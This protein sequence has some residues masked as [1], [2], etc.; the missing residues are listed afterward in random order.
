MKK[1]LSLMLVLALT[2]GCV[3]AL[4]AGVTV[5]SSDF[6]QGPDGWV[7]RSMGSAWI[8]AE[9]GA[10]RIEGR[11]SDWHSPGRDFDLKE[12]VRYTLRVLVMQSETEHA[13]FMIS[14]AHKL[15]GQET[16]ENLAFAT[17][18]RGAWTTLQCEYTP[19][20]FDSYVLYVETKGAPTLSYSIKN[21]VVA[22]PDGIPRDG[23]E[24]VQLPILKD[25]YAGQFDIGIAVPQ[26]VIRNGGPALALVQE[27]FNI[28]TP[29]NE[30]KPD[31]VLDVAAS[32]R[33][34]QEDETAAAVHFDAAKPLLDFAK[35][36]GI[37][38]HG[39]VLVW[40][41]QTPEAFFHEGYDPA[42]PYVSREVM[43][44]RLE[45]YI[46]GVMEYMDENYPGVVVS[47]DVVN[48]AIDDGGNYLRPSNWTKVVGDDFLARAFEL[49]RKY[50]P[51]GTLLYYN[52]YNTAVSGK[53]IKIVKLLESLIPEGNID[54]YGFQMHHSITYPGIRAIENCVAKIAALGLRLRISEL[55]VGIDKNDDASLE[56]QALLYAQ[57]MRLARKYADQFEAVQ[58]WGLTDSLSWRSGNFPLIFDGARSP[59]PA[60]WAVAD[61]DSYTD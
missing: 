26:F 33:L 24:A 50:A 56:A 11:E 46:R 19:A 42:K 29:E 30:L 5:Y 12:G 1:I 23:E 47:W 40:H 44:G 6:T 59:K 43:L 55:D 45:N 4:A 31:S 36:N 37:K 16:Y 10:L 53:L 49:A 51:E 20:Y 15:N 52:D 57:V 60:F 35:E 28:L 39:H 25:V 13:D 21:F 27:Q 54:G 18:N 38:V 41:S 61:P 7:A 9:N 8:T 17:V 58:I 2:L 48:E 22:A 32:K 14:V 34:A 3:P